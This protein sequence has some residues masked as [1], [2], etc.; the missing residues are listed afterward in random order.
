[1]SICIYIKEKNTVCHIWFMCSTFSGCLKLVLSST[2]L[3]SVGGKLVCNVTGA[4]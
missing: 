4:A 3:Q 1:M 2:L